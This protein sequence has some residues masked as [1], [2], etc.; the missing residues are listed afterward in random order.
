M[1]TNLATNKHVAWPSCVW[2]QLS[3]FPFPVGHPMS[4]GCTL[5]FELRPFL[6]VFC[7]LN[8]RGHSHQKT[9]EFTLVTLWFVLLSAQQPVTQSPDNMA[10]IGTVERSHPSSANENTPSFL[11]STQTKD[12]KPHKSPAARLENTL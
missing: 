1:E 9:A 3:F 6:T 8:R 4:A 5:I 10:E 12:T 2:L 11:T 7:L